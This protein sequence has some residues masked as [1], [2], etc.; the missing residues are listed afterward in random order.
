MANP[1]SLWKFLAVRY[2]PLEVIHKLGGV[3][4]RVLQTRQWRIWRRCYKRVTDSAARVP[5]LIVTG[6]KE[7]EWPRVRNLRAGTKM[8]IDGTEEPVTGVHKSHWQDSD[9]CNSTIMNER[10]RFEECC[11]EADHSG[12]QYTAKICLHVPRSN[13]LLNWTAFYKLL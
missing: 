4:E 5:K 12:I 11:R 2:L 1:Q 10:Q 8:K 9:R 6:T 7:V 3:I 13:Y